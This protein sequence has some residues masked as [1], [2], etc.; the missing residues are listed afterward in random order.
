MEQMQEVGSSVKRL[1]EL[2]AGM[3]LAAHDDKHAPAGAAV[4]MRGMRRRTWTGPAWLNLTSGS[5]ASS[6]HTLQCS[7][8][9]HDPD[10]DHKGF[11]ADSKM[12]A[13]TCSPAEAAGIVS[14]FCKVCRSASKG[15][16]HAMMWQIIA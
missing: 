11:W 8:P 7:G 14:I 12:P 4:L 1:L 16:A 2:E 3:G 15:Q 5:Q 6:Y 10:P 13:S 9:D